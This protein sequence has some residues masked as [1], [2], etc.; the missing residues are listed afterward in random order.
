MIGKIAGALIITGVGIISFAVG[1]LLWKKEKISLLHNYHVERVSEENKSA[2][3]RLSGL[4][5][6]VIGISLLMTALVLGITESAWSFLCFAAG[7][8]VG[9]AMLIAAGIKYNR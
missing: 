6:I 3:C 7:F 8:A 1:W 4:G 2:F 9:L 5:M